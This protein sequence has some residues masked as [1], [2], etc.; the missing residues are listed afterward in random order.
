MLTIS[1]IQEAEIG[2]LCAQRQPQ[3]FIN[4]LYQNLKI[5]ECKRSRNTS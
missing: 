3:N 1:V 2:G 5:K 4:V